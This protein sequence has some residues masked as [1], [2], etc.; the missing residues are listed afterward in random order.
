MTF[1]SLKFIEKFL[2]SNDDLSDANMALSDADVR[3]DQNATLLNVGLWVYAKVPQLLSCNPCDDT[4]GPQRSAVVH[5]SLVIGVSLLV[6][7]V[8]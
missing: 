3:L 4:L 5:H 6:W 1:S 7:F 8:G 2:S